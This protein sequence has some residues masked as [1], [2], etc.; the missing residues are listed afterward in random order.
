MDNLKN[1]ASN[2]AQ[3]I[4][5][6][7]KQEFAIDEFNKVRI[8]EC[9]S[10]INGMFQIV[11]FQLFDKTIDGNEFEC[12]IALNKAGVPISA[13]NTAEQINAGLDIIRTLSEFYNVSAPIFVD[14]AE[15]VNRFINPT[16]QMVYVRVTKEPVLTISNQ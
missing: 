12:C 5:D 16:S 10:R 11:K 13:T 14:S 15:S 7:E 6:I 4:A 9:E 1:E 2:Y 3:Q 8:D